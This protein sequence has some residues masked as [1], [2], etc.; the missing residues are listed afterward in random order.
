MPA[1]IDR[2]EAIDILR[3]AMLTRIGDSDMSACRCAAEQGVFCRGFA[4][5][6]ETELRQ[7]YDWITR[8][9]PSLTRNQLEGIADRWQLARQEVVEVPI[10]CDMQQKSGDM[11]RGWSDFPNDKLS[12][13]IKEMTGKSVIVG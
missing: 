12:L 10:A 13:F 1:Q 3:A 2:N 8:R 7:S 9:S 11:C 6:S 4:R 5:F